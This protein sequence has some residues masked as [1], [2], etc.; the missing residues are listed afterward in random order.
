M[1]YGVGV[2]A[3]KLT[4]NPTEVAGCRSVGSVQIPLEQRSAIDPVNAHAALQEQ[5]MDLG[6][7]IA[8]ITDGTA[9]TPVAGVAY[10]CDR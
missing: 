6:G 9:S 7:N 2:A 3:A 5:T 4:T 8:L 1:S 10:S